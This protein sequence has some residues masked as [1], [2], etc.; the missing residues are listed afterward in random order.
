MN[1][2]YQQIVD[3]IAAT[4][5]ANVRAST[6]E[7]LALLVMGMIK[8][9]HASPARIAAAL[10]ELGLTQAQESSIERRIRRL[11]NDPQL[12]ATLC[13]HPFA[14]HHLALSRPK[15]LLLALDPTT[16]DDRVV[17][18]TAAVWY[19]GRALP[20]A[21]LVW[22]ANE[23][24]Q[25]AGFWE[26]V[27]QLLDHVA[28][29]LPPEVKVTWVADRAFGTPA[30]IDLVVARG[31]HYVV[32]VQGQTRCRDR[33]KREH[34]VRYLFRPH[35]RRA[36][37]R[38]QVF[39]SRGW[40]DASV[41]ALWGRRHKT[42]LCLVSDLPPKWGLLHLYRR[43]Y[44]IEALFRHYKSYGWHWEHG[45]VTDLNHI[46]RLLVG[47]AWATWLVLLAG[48]VEVLQFL[49]KKPTGKRRTRPHCGKHSLFW[50]GLKR[51]QRML[52]SSRLPL[53]NWI[54]AD[55]LAPTWQDQIRWHH[56]RV[57]VFANR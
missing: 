20:L 38:G 7:R 5:G 10:H 40:R 55:W 13:F 54:L 44:T 14:K 49:S 17:M 9:K 30:F 22:P 57:F 46:Q 45:Q 8:A 19:R 27:E 25:G 18:L 33:L 32:R 35:K 51:L 37:M 56:A 43:R 52:F 39:K 2:V 24:L 6:Q 16:Q 15:E 12:T 26:R 3:R 4:V 11:E 21:W 36:K 34:Q 28:Q 42:P 41:V 1:I 23:P 31:W 50:H 47:M 29:I 48:T 53:L